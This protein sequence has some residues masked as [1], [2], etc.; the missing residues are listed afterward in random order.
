MFPPM[1]N[2]RKKSVKKTSNKKSLEVIPDNKRYG[3]PETM[4]DNKKRGTPETM[5][6]N[7]R[8]SNFHKNW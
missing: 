3:K 5:P 8:R 1:K 2:K 7:K 6:D 4:P